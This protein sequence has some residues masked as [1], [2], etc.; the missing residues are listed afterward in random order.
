MILMV[1]D[2]EN[3]DDSNGSDSVF[4]IIPTMAM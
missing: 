1:T 2:V 3:D 4:M